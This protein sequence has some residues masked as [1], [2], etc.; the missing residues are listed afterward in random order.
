V[1]GSAPRSTWP[2]TGAAARSAGSAARAALAGELR[3]TRTGHRP[4]VEVGCAAIPSRP[5]L[6]RC[7]NH[8]DPVMTSYL[9]PSSPR[10]VAAAE[11]LKAHYPPSPVGDGVG[12]GRQIGVIQPGGLPARSAY[13]QLE[14]LVFTKPAARAAT[15]SASVTCTGASWRLC[16][17]AHPLA[18]RGRRCSTRGPVAPVTRAPSVQDAILQRPLGCP[19]VVFSK[20]RAVHLLLLSH[21]RVPSRIRRRSWTSCV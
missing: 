8:H 16:R 21:R 13:L 19:P 11:N 9:P 2:L 14:E 12:H 5:A 18:R 10:A 3:C 20:H 15:K 6:S 1:V 17:A 4:P 7:G